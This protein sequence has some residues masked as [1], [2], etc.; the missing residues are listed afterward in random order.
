MSNGA[1]IV[2]GALANKP[3]NGGNAWT[4]LNWLL[5]FRRSGFD[6]YFIEEINSGT[7]VG[8]SNQPVAPEDSVNAA[9]FRAVMKQFGFEQR[10]SLLSDN[11]TAVVG[12]GLDRLEKLAG[13]ADMLLNIS[14]HLQRAALKLAPRCKIYLDDDPGY[15]QCWHAAGQLG[16][17]LA[18]HDHYFTLG[19]NIGTSL[20]SIPAGDIHWRTTRVPIVLDEWP[21]IAPRNFDRFTT[22]ASWRGAFGT[23]TLDGKTHGP[24]AHEFRKFFALPA[25]S[26]LKFQIVLNIDPADWKDRQALVNAGWDIGSPELAATPDAFRAYVQNS[27]A[28]FSVAQ[29]IY[30]G[31]RSGWFSDRSAAYLASG[32]PTLLQDTGFSRHLP[33]GEGLV[34]FTT[35]EEAMEGAAKIASNYPRHSRAARALAEQYFDSDKVLAKLLTD[36]SIDDAQRK[37]KPA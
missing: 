23:V 14:G 32:K 25:K 18:G 4:R 7:C 15:T 34:T 24:K 21:P 10:A 17:R 12:I 8:A 6:P 3:S 11:G 26:G 36:I 16:N 5:G 13:R 30:V 2:A 27:S 35:L 19:A 20:C 33:T 9:Y 29:P 31:T 22:V 28:E 37:N 1:V